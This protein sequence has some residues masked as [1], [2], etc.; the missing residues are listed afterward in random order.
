MRNAS[1]HGPFSVTATREDQRPAMSS[2]TPELG[3]RDNIGS[4]VTALAP[5][6]KE[7]NRKAAFCDYEKIDLLEGVTVRF[8]SPSV[9]KA[10]DQSRCRKGQG[11]GEVGVREDSK[12]RPLVNQMIPASKVDV[13]NIQSP[14]SVRLTLAIE[15]LE[16][17]L[18]YRDACRIKSLR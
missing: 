1:E 4:C 13:R 10:S 8:A 15:R 16:N 6:D 11:T 18:H 17:V 5:K 14:Q 3:G 9:P 7:L 2:Q 12:P